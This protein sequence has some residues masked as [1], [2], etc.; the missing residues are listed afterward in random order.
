MSAVQKIT[1]TLT[2]G[3]SRHEK[4]AEV[5]RY[6][7]VGTTYLKNV[8]V[9]GRLATLLRPGEACTLWVAT[10]RTPTPL[11]FSTEIHMVYAMEVDGVLHQAV[12]DVRREWSASK[13]LAFFIL[14]GVGTMTIFMY[15]GILFW[16]NAIRLM[17]VY[18]PVREMRQELALVNSEKT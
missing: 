3:R 18:L 7:R 8:K 4:A 15:I 1:G 12:D 17:A 5:Y 14:M 9:V 11:L 2:M 16:I 13:A 10:I 6:L